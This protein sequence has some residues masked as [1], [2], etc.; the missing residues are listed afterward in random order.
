MS[1]KPKA[2]G[3]NLPFMSPRV[4]TSVGSTTAA[5]IVVSV[6]NDASEIFLSRPPLSVHTVL[7][8]ERKVSIITNRR[9]SSKAS[10]A[11]R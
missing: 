5:Y 1:F 4:R 6:M 11:V 10:P 8:T 7:T 3:T 2:L 9:K